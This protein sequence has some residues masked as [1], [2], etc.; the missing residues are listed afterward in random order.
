M[1][2]EGME[3]LHADALTTL[4]G[5]RH[6][7]FTRKGGV[8]GG[9]YASLNTGLGS[10]DA[11]E[12]ALENRARAMGALGAEVLVTPHQIHSG[13]C[14]IVEGPWPDD[15][16]QR[17]DAVATCRPGVAV[18]VNTADCTPVLFADGRAGVVAAAHAGWKG[19]IGGVLEATI[20][21]MEEL[22]AKRADIRCAIGPVI[23]QA[24][25]EVGPEFH[26][27]F[28]GEDGDYARFFIASGRAG[29][30]LF[31]LPGFVAHVLARAGVGQVEDV[32]ACTYGDEAR[33]YSYRRAT[34]RGEPDYGRQ[35]SAIIL[36]P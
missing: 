3:I 31:D 4:E 8:S 6:G 2:G 12:N 34:H 20:A 10:H 35:L 11:R 30:F 26:A 24:N 15:E 13:V 19:A 17:A 28:M 36:T 22:G 18:A 29:H 5:V 7:F 9:I 23:S 27:R 14:A 21:R 16:P 32:G 33:F 25:Y 1:T